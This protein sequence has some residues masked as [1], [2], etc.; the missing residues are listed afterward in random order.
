[1]LLDMYD[2]ST[3]AE[4]AKK[5][6][7]KFKVSLSENGARKAYERY[8]YP[9]INKQ[10]KREGPKMLVLDIETSPLLA[11]VWSL[12]NNNFIGLNQLKK[13]WHLMSFAAK[14]YGDDNPDNIIYMD[15]R[16]VKNVEDDR[17]QLKAIWKLLDEADILITQNGKKFDT[18]KINARFV[19][20]GM[21]PPSSYRNID[22]YLIAKRHFGF[23]SNKL[24]YMTDKLC[25]TYK[26][27]SHGKFPGQKLWTECLKG[28]ME[29]WDEMEEY[30]KYDILSLEEL[31][32]ILV[33]WDDSINFTIYFEDDVC[34][35]G[36]TDI[37]KNGFYFTNANKYQKYVCHGTDC[38]A[39]FRDKKAIK[40][41]NKFRKT[42]RRG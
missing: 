7:K 39:E 26:K 18:K 16:H 35:C 23:T 21:K 14:W 11:N 29:A 10:K 5:I 3:Y 9:T 24:E 8:K 19:L 42:N 1:M 13:D 31:Y 27:L 37:R 40:S 36:S 22:T 33:P 15:Q 12:W 20:N 2:T 28:N 41:N 38:G 32:D 25:K 34:S 30:N 6:S 17:K 4:I